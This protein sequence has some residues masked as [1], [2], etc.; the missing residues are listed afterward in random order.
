MYDIVTLEPEDIVVITAV[1]A[2]KDGEGA[3]P[4]RMEIFDCLC[5]IIFARRAM[6]ENLPVRW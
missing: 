3:I 1:N 2:I 4:A 6:A 5:L